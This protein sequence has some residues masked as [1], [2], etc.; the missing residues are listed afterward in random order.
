MTLTQRLELLRE[1]AR[2]ARDNHHE[3]LARRQV[4][5]DDGLLLTADE[6]R[7]LAAAH[8][9]VRPN[10]DVRETLRRLALA[11]SFEHLAGLASRR[12]KGR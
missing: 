6:Y 1:V 11:R 10:D 5:P 3:R 8:R 2:S 7:A 4:D 9:E 12:S